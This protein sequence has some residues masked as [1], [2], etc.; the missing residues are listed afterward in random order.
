[1]NEGLPTPALT[2][3][4]TA[5]GSP[6]P[7]VALASTS[8][9]KEGSTNRQAWSKRAWSRIVDQLANIGGV[10]FVLLVLVAA[11]GI[12]NREVFFSES[13]LN[14]LLRQ[15]SFFAIMAFGM[16][17]LITMREF[18]LSVGSTYAVTIL[19]A[20]D[21][22]SDGMSP[23]LAA[24]AGLAAG[25]GLGLLTGLI[26]RVLGVS[27]FIVSLGAL[28]LYRGSAQVLTDGRPVSG[29][30]LESTFFTVLGGT[31]GPVPAAAIVALVLLVVLHV[32]FTRTRFGS[33][34]R[35]IGSNPEAAA[36]AG[37][38]LQRVRTYVLMLL[39]LLAGVSG[40]MTLA[41]FGSA[42]PTLGSGYELTVIAAVVIGATPLSGGRGS[43]VG[44]ALGAL[45][46]QIIQSGL[47]FYR[48]NPIWSTFTTGAVIIGAVALDAVMRRR[49]IIPGS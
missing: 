49:R 3:T 36:F 20:A 1:M 43:I 6:A 9:T 46:I 38:R 12:P 35:S 41:H 48:I 47:V 7:V 2:S 37:L 10:V 44:A 34:V 21:L 8:A 29:L 30:P 32:V 4:D 17:F 24:G 28:S 27:V 22:M 18:D 42:D 11:V 5:A 31:V 26:A 25:V 13:A 16:V 39:G 14:S 15:S 45:I 19:L 33:Q 23:W 40:M